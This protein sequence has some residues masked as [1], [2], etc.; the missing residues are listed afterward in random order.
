MP[1]SI[2]CYLTIPE[3]IMN[4][5]EVWKLTDSDSDSAQ[6]DRNKRK[7]NRVGVMRKK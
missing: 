5:E 1:Q 2:K 4:S 3:F 6:S 7:K